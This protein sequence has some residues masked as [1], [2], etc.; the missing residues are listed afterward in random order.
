MEDYFFCQKLLEWGDKKTRALCG[1]VA[2]GIRL[3][4]GKVDAA[5]IILIS[6]IRQI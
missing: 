5:N 1:E 3:E 6:A 2:N 4:M